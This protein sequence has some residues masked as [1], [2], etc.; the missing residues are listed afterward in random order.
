MN[1]KKPLKK[2]VNVGKD[3]PEGLNLNDLKQFGEDLDGSQSESESDDDDDDNFIDSESQ[4]ETDTELDDY[5]SL[6]SDSDEPPT[7]SPPKK[8]FFKKKQP[9]AMSNINPSQILQEETDFVSEK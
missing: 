2:L 4:K 6:P 9:L 7:P 1:T 3:L 5:E 8:I